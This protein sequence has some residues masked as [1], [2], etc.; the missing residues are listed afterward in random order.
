MASAEEFNSSYVANCVF[1]VFLCYTAIMLNSVTIYILRKASSLPKTLRT[2]LLN[3][4][5]SDLA[6]GLF[7]Q[8]L[9]IAVLVMKCVKNID[10]SMYNFTHTAF[11][12]TLTLF[13]WVSFLTVTALS[14]DRFLTIHFHLRYHELVT[15]KRAVTA[16]VSTWVISSCILA[17]TLWKPSG[18]VIY[19][20]FFI[21]DVTCYTTSS[22]VNYKTYLVIRQHQHHIQVLRGVHAQ[23]D[24]QNGQIVS[25]GRERHSA[26]A[27]IYLQLVVL[28][29]YLPNTCYN[30]WT[31]TTNPSQSLNEVIEDYTLT[32]VFLNSSV[33]PLVYC[34]KMRQVRRSVVEFIRN[35]CEHRKGKIA[36]QIN[37]TAARLQSNSLENIP[38]L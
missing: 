26:V 24:T 22:F 31:L 38:C 5:V 4:S 29:C 23:Q 27:I 25:V 6:V 10:D 17:V 3:L 15:R 12:I 36:W 18:D 21:T 7:V 9:F 1:N 32:M 8:P 19:L 20:V 30:L 2:L 14:V 28:A 37:R 11:R 34:W 13:A 16:V 35:M 33:N